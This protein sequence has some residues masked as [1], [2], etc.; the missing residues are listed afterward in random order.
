M[1]ANHQELQGPAHLGPRSRLSA[2]RALG[3]D[4][5][6]LSALERGIKAPLKQVPLPLHRPCSRQ[7]IQDLMPTIQE[8]LDTGAIQEMS[9]Q[10]AALTKY[11]VPIFP[12]PKKDDDKVRMITDLRSLN[13]CCPAPRHRAETWANVLQ[14]VAQQDNQWGLT[15]HLQSYFHH[16]AIHQKTARWMPFQLGDRAFQVVGMPF[17]W[18]LSPWWAQKLAKPVRAWMASQ[19]W[20]YAWW[21]D[22]ILVLGPSKAETDTR[23]TALVSVLT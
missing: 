18:N 10:D 17:G 3:A 7:D 21:V 16:L 15:L 12:R 11:W 8:Y 19:G 4:N 1:Q 13:A 9:L 5:V 6:L 22:D 23:A 20:S 14:Q 2:W